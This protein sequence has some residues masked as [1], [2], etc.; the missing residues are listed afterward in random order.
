MSSKH[1][2]EI[3]SVAG[4]PAIHQVAKSSNLRWSLI[5]PCW[6]TVWFFFN[7]CWERR[8]LLSMCLGK[9]GQGQGR[10]AIVGSVNSLGQA[11][12]KP[13]ALNYP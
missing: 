7:L 5:P 9:N 11:K 8:W 13:P 3:A 12:G 1:H 2:E 10:R 4:V 6:Q